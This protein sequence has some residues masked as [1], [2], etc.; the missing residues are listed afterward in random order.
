M[1]RRRREINSTSSLEIH[2]VSSSDAD[3]RRTLAIRENSARSSH[4]REFSRTRVLVRP[5]LCRHRPRV[6]ALFLLASLSTSLS[7]DSTKVKRFKEHALRG[8][9]EKKIA[10]ARARRR[11]CIPLFSPFPLPPL[12]LFSSFCPGATWEK[13]DGNSPSLFTKSSSNGFAWC[14]LLANFF[15]Y[16]SS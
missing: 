5:I 4:A 2:R 9:V 10:T 11:N 6:I 13:L 8:K 16:D 12:S 14:L 7:P 1:R 15:H 3:K